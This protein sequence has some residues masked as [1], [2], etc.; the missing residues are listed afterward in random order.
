MV[1]EVQRET[2]PEHPRKSIRLASPGSVKGQ[3]LE[4]A[5]AHLRL[6]GGVLHGEGCDPFQSG[7]GRMKKK[8]R[9]DRGSS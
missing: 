2:L 7:R 1:A 6:S 4:L 8:P 3:L 5:I 9:Y